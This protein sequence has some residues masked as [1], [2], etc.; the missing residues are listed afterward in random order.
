MMI[1][2]I[3]TTCNFLNICGILQYVLYVVIA[4]LN[5]T[6][7]K[8]SSTFKLGLEIRQLKFIV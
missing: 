3:K 8:A 6:V 5:I 4:D 2:L 1:V 7:S